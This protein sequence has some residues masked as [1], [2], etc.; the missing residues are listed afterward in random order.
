[1]LRQRLLLLGLL[2]RFEAPPLEL[3]PP[4]RGDAEA[5]QRAADQALHHLGGRPQ[6]PAP[7]I[8]RPHASKSRATA[9]AARA[10]LR[11]RRRG[12]LRPTA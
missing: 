4:Q 2:G 11:R 7:R 12:I 1:V 9:V 5:G 3:L 6:L 8:Q 10:P